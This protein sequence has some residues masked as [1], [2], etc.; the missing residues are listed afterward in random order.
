MF[1]WALGTAAAKHLD[2]PPPS[3]N[4]RRIWSWAG[5]LRGLNRG[6][7][8]NDLLE[9]AGHDGPRHGVAR[10]PPFLG[11][12][13]IECVR[14]CNCRRAHC[15]YPGDYRARYALMTT[16]SALTEDTVRSKSIAPQPSSRSQHPW[17]KGLCCAIRDTATRK[18]ATGL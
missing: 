10:V 17:D 18:E 4:Q 16:G 8:L 6:G 5:C 9:T 14:Y 2:N 1:G 3:I 11:V 12:L 15:D 7:Q 13:M